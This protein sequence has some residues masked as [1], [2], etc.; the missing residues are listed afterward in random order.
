MNAEQSVAT[1]LNP[2]GRCNDRDD[3]FGT[4]TDQDLTTYPSVDLRL[5]KTVT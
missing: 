2:E 4:L 5:F 1:A 3:Y